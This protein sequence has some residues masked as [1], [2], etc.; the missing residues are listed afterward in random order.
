GFLG[1][2]HQP[3]NVVDPS[4]GVENLKALVDDKQFGDRV[5]LLEDLERGFYKDYKADSIQA[6]Q[7]TYQRAVTLMQSKEGKAFDLAQEPAKAKE[8]YGS[9]K[10]GEGCLLARRLI[11]TGVS[12]VEVSLGGWD[13]H[14][15]NF[16]RVK[17]LSKTVDP[18]MS[19]LVSDLKDRGLLDSTLVIWM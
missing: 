18:A 3:L 16:D 17:N 1:A 8:A 11:E 14:Q 4:K 5:G 19:A 7:T 13:T 6:H 12:F 15:D 10:F 9:T 2:R